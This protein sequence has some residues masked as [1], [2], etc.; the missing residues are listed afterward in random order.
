[1]SISEYEQFQKDNPHMESQPTAPQ[2]ISG[3]TSLKP[4]NGFREILKKI[5]KKHPKG[6]VNDFGGPT[7]V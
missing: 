1:M 5:K 4:D 6:K 2:I 3:V 7:N